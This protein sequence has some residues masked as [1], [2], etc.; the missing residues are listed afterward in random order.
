MSSTTAV[1]ASAAA[2]CCLCKLCPAQIREECLD[3]SKVRCMKVTLSYHH[4]QACMLLCVL[5]VATCT[6]CASASA[7]NNCMLNF[8]HELQ[9]LMS[10]KRHDDHTK[11]RASAIRLLVTDWCNCSGHR[12]CNVTQDC[13]TLHSTDATT[14]VPILQDLWQATNATA[15]G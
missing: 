2:A 15:S 9:R 4:K 13:L 10:M 7:K 14:Q 12:G 11:L 3:R 1:S 5:S 6:A 8:L